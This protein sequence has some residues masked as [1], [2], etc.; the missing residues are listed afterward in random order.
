ML[1]EDPTDAHHE[2]SLCPV[3]EAP[4]DRF[5]VALATGLRYCSRAHARQHVEK[6]EMLRCNAC[7]ELVEGSE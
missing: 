2:N 4:A 1:S 6:G 3:C 7:G 5:V